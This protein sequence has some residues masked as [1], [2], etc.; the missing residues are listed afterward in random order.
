MTTQEKTTSSAGSPRAT[1]KES[2]D[3]ALLTE[4]VGYQLAQATI[5]TSRVFQTNVGK[6]HDLN[7]VEYTMLALIHAN[8]GVAPTQLRN[9]LGISKPYVT[10]GLEKLSTRN[11]ISRQVNPN[12]QRAQQLHTTADAAQLLDALTQKLLDGEKAALFTLTPAERT[13]LGELLHKLAQ[14]RE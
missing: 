4:L 8:P 7:A 9:A 1:P 11:L 5:V 2:L 14:A 10:T 3:E 13:T 6:P 12:D